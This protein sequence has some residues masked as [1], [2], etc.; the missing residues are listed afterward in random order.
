MTGVVIGMERSI[1]DVAENE[2]SITVCATV[3]TRVGMVNT[4]VYSVTMRTVS[5]TDAD[6]N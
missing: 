6:Y 3:Q 4:R 5:G 1:Y 2:G